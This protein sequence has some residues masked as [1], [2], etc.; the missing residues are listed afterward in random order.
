MKSRAQPRCFGACSL[1]GRANSRPGCLVIASRRQCVVDQLVVLML[2]IG[3]PLVV[4][5]V[6]GTKEVGLSE[7]GAEHPSCGALD[8]LAEDSI[9]VPL[10]HESD[11]AIARQPIGASKHTGVAALNIGW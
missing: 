3:L 4:P 1:P 10:L 5:C 11:L 8:R 7:E 9:D 2:F 6:V